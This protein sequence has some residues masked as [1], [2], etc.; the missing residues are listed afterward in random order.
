MRLRFLRRADEGRR[1][2]TEAVG[3]GRIASHEML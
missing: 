3:M 1:R 2:G